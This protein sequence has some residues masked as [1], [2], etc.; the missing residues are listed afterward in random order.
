MIHKEDY[1]CFTEMNKFFDSNTIKKNPKLGADLWIFDYVPFK[2][3]RL[4]KSN[5]LYRY[6]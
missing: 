4:L 5:L 3:K 1:D 2:I 6:L